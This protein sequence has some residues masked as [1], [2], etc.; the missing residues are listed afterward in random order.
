V[1]KTVLLWSEPAANT[2]SKC[3][4]DSNGGSGVGFEQPHRGAGSYCAYAVSNAE[5]AICQGDT[6]WLSGS[7]PG[8]IFEQYSAAEMPALPSTA[9]TNCSIRCHP[10]FWVTCYSATELTRLHTI[11]ITSTLSKCDILGRAP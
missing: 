2:I 3:H 7:C 8:D 9:D 5:V 1:V 11:H 4:R 10:P 6:C